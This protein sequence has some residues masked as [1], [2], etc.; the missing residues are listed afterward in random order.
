MDINK[1]HF[2]LSQFSFS[3]FVSSIR[4]KFINRVLPVLLCFLFLFSVPSFA[5]DDD[6]LHLSDFTSTMQRVTND[7]SVVKKYD[8]VDGVVK[9]GGH[10]MH[11]FTATD[12]AFYASGGTH[13]L[14]NIGI[15]GVTAGHEYEMTFYVGLSFNGKIQMDVS[16]AGVSVYSELLET[17]WKTRKINLKF[18]MPDTVTDQTNIIIQYAVPAAFG[19]GSEGQVVKYYISEDIEFTDKTDNPGWLAKIKQWFSELGD[20]IGSFFTNLTE[21]IKGFFADLKENLSTFFSELGDRIKGFFVQLVEDIKSLFIPPD[22]YFSSLQ[23]QLDTFCTEH[24]GALYQ[25]P[26]VLINLIKKVLSISPDEPS[27]TMPSIQF[28]WKG[29][30]IQLTEPIQYSFSWV[31]DSSHPLYTFYKFYRGFS[32]VSMFVAFLA[33]LRH[34]YITIFGG[35]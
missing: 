13:V 28:Y 4:G 27:I 16:V 32:I 12:P 9:Y 35:D 10:Q 23:T 5:A 8:F 31:S 3:S 1:Q 18:T 33:Y 17:A 25:G 30:L 34:K 20:K 24:L 21:S 2:I 11:Y 14:T 22:D 7:G 15:A 6:V 26:T 29:K 19:Y